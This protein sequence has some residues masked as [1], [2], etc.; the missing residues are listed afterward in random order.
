MASALSPKRTI[1]GATSSPKFPQHSYRARPADNSALDDNV[2]RFYNG[3]NVPPRAIRLRSREICPGTTLPIFLAAAT[4]PC[5]RRRP[6]LTCA[7]FQLELFY[8]QA[9]K[10]IRI[11]S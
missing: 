9:S 7:M 10:S 6:V 1:I 5:A 3:F 2:Y 8:R 11:V 4:T